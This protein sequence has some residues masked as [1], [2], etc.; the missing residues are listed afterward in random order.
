MPLR[1]SDLGSCKYFH[2]IAPCVPEFLR[3]RI[4]V[5]M[6]LGEIEAKELAVKI[7]AVLAESL[8]RRRARCGRD[9]TISGRCLTSAEMGAEGDE[10]YATDS[11]W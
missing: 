7:R 5:E 9:C 10:S 2:K 8:L 6:L 1:L 4:F 3:F 11:W